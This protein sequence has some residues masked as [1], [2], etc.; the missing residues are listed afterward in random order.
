MPVL[1]FKPARGAE[2]R[3]AKLAA[4]RKTPD[5][6]ADGGGLDAPAGGFAAV[7][8]PPSPPPPPQAVTLQ[9]ARNTKAR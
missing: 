3:A 5:V 9:T 8:L 7:L 4:G 2:H 6:H 1:G